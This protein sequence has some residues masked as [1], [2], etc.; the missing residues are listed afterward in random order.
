MNHTTM[1]GASFAIFF[2][3]CLWP[4]M[5]VGQPT[6]D[7]AEGPN[8][9]LAHDRV[10]FA[11]GTVRR[12]GYDVNDINKLR[13][14]ATDASI[15]VRQDA[16]IVATHR[17]GQE[18]I[19]ILVR[20][21]DDPWSL[22]RC[23]AARMLGVLGNNSGLGRM[24]EDM[25][26]LTIPEQKEGPS[27]GEDRNGQPRRLT[28]QSKDH[29]LYDA[30]E[31]AE[32]LAEF[33]DSSGYELAAQAALQSRYGPVRIPAVVVLAKISRIDEDTLKAKG[34]DPEAVLLQVVESDKEPSVLGMV[35]N[36][37][38][39][40]MKLEAKIRILDAVERSPRASKL[41]SLQRQ[42]IRNSLTHARKQVE[43]KKDS[44]P[45]KKE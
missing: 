13:L 23:T 42:A 37:A 4:V 22:V 40:H 7:P 9:L 35:A 41:T 16:L 38:M 45:Q 36:C 25:V 33:G 17:H 30:L 29:R 15:G 21:L 14:A 26:E 32:V 44:A 1:N 5:C 19:P 31:A 28:P 12:K 20:A 3:L 6:F 10:F 27:K 24:R 18:A 34:Y 2:I 8:R 43:Q 11:E 39:S